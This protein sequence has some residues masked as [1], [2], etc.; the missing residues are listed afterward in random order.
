MQL[1][2]DKVE[3]HRVS[4]ELHRALWGKCCNYIH[5][6]I[7]TRLLALCTNMFT[8]HA[9]TLAH[10]PLPSALPSIRDSWDSLPWSQSCC[11]P[12]L[13]NLPDILPFLPPRP[14]T[15][16][17]LWT[18]TCYLYL[19]DVSDAILSWFTHI[20]LWASDS[21]SGDPF[22]WSPSYPWFSFCLS[23]HNCDVVPLWLSSQLASAPGCFQVNHLALQ[24]PLQRPL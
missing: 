12:N 3:V 19:I 4:S 17:N 15:K 10:R 9:I 21:F 2:L 6:C 20:Y 24:V 23:Q 13:R 8:I 7:L 11:Q 16:R 22:A 18:P 1:L 14:Q 5:H